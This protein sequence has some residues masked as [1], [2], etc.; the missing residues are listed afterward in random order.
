[1][2]MFVCYMYAHEP[3]ARLA[4]RVGRPSEI[5]ATWVWP[6]MWMQGSAVCPL[7]EQVLLANES[8]LLPF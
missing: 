6:A 5:G 1:M 2:Q 4:R 8:S 7:Q 3:P